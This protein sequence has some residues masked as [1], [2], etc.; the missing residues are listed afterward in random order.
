MM[1]R[2][3]A[4]EALGA[5]SDAAAPLMI[6]GS[7]A[8]GDPSEDSDIDVLVLAPR[9]TQPVKRGRVNVSAYDEH[10]LLGMA[11]RGSLFVLHL[12]NEGRVLRDRRGRLEH[13]LNSYRAP[14]SYKPVRTTLRGVANLLDATEPQ[15][16]QRWKGYNEVALFVLRTLLYAHFAEAGDPVFS[17]RVIRQRMHREDLEVALA[18]KTSQNPGFVEFAVAR[19][20]VEE[21]VE[22]KVLNPFGTVEALIANTALENPSVL[23]FG[24]RLL[25]RQT[26]EF[27]YHL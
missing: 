4:D 15:Y 24:L 8:R 2:E 23:A 26:S 7:F 10:T 19:S 12:R 20:L 5:V 27:R 18:L 6:F 1:Q 14:N 22:A 3:I 25:G 21:F 11:E 17:L 16:T 9:G 13:C